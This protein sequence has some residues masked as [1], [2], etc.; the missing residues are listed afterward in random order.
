[1]PKTTSSRLTTAKAARKTTGA[2]TTPPQPAHESD[3]GVLD[4]A[5]IAGRAYELF[6]ADGSRHGHDLEHWLQA[7]REIRQ[8]VLTS[9]A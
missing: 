6:L 8:R 1:M 7:E 9:A 3:A 2:K 5:V 4:Y